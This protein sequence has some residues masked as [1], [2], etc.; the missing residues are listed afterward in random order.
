MFLTIRIYSELLGSSRW[1]WYLSFRVPSWSPSMVILRLDLV[2]RGWRWRW[3]AFHRDQGLAV[4]QKILQE[5][6]TG[7]T[8]VNNAHPWP[9]PVMS[10]SVTEFQDPGR[11][12]WLRF[13]NRSG[14]CPKMEGT[15]WWY[16]PENAQSAGINLSI[17]YG[18]FSWHSCW[19]LCNCLAGV[20]KITGAFEQQNPRP[21]LFTSS[22]RPKGGRVSET[23]DLWKLVITDVQ[24]PALARIAAKPR[25]QLF[26]Q[27]TPA[28]TQQAWHFWAAEALKL[29]RTAII[30]CCTPA[31][32][33]RRASKPGRPD[34]L[35]NSHHGMVDKGMAQA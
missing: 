8:Q 20:G 26:V 28:P 31:D 9:A 10:E 4:C 11:W 15:K 6:G 13:W 35:Q 25:P 2:L 7:I 5:C 24:T 23:G 21:Q 32:L 22:M 18:E 34:S 27:E 16:Y 17:I 30:T 29:L 3:W 1:K 14:G 12:S 33:C 19:L